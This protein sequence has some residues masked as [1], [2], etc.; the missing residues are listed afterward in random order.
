MSKDLPVYIETTSEGLL[1][2][3]IEQL[4]SLFSP[5]TLCPRRCRINRLAGERGYCKAPY[6]IYISSAFPHFGEEPPLVGKNGSGTIFFTHCNLKCCFCQNYEISVYGEGTEYSPD[7]LSEIMLKLQER[8]CHNINLVTPTH[9]VPNILKGLLIAVTQGLSIP[10]VYNCGGYESLEV[11]KIL[12]G[13]VDIYMPDIKFLD[14]LL[15]ERYCNAKDYP[16]VVMNVVMEM[17]RQVGDLYIDEKGIAKKG[18]LLR[19]LV[20]PGLVDDTKKVLDFIRWKIS[21]HAFVNIMAQYHPCYLSYSHPELMRGITKSEFYEVLDY[22]RE[23]GL[24]RA[25]PY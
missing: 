18:L 17:E 22:S 20:M 9:Y 5:C 12:E 4:E 15:S 3:K 6:D 11:I 19:H 7:R 23:I 24:I 25:F 10:I 2:K 16:E 21:E 8:G 14:P 1:E 13:V